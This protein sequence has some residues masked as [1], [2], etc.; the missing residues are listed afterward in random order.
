MEL[1][2]AELA[3]ST[4]STL[5]LAS[6]KFPVGKKEDLLGLVGVGDQ[7]LVIPMSATMISPNMQ[8]APRRL[9]PSISVQLQPCV[10]KT[11]DYK[12][13]NRLAR[14]SVFRRLCTSWIVT[15]KRLTGKREANEVRCKHSSTGSLPCNR[16]LKV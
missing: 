4:A 14:S 1:S 11:M 15:W 16:W 5:Q 7:Q 9:H 3:N 6:S 13:V 2:C 12:L 8:H 10:Q